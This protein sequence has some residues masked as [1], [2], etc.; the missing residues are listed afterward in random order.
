MGLPKATLPF[1]D[2]TML[3][4]VVRLLSQVVQPVVVVAAPEQTLPDLPIDTLIARDADEGLGPI[5]GL[6]AGLTVIAPHVDAVYATSCD[7]PLLS[8]DFVRQMIAELR[9][10]D[11][12]VPVEGEFHHP[13]AAVYRAG[14]LPA[15]RELLAAN[16]L[17][18]LFLFEAVRT[19]RVPVEQLRA[20]DPQLLT[21]MNLNRPQDYVQ[22]L[23]LAGLAPDPAIL[24]ALEANA[25]DR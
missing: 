1:G 11:V 12:A 9:D 21:L 5:A 8:T 14:V 2:E 3:H 20:A 17:R 6:V 16:R 7:V 4:R 13:L 19:T 10:R 22:S 15:A 18:P 24:A 25:I 23:R